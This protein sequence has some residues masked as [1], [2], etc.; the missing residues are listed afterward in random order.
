MTTPEGKVK[1][2]V[3]RALE[4]LPSVYRFMPVQNGM[5]APGLDFY[6]CIGGLFVAI[7]TKVPGK[8]LTARQL[9]TAQEIASAGGLVFVI[10]NDD[11][12]EHMVARLHVHV[13][14]SPDKP[15]GFVFDNSLSERSFRGH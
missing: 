13:Q 3:K 4:K 5:G 14:F 6:L 10:R 1:A 7:E 12:I 2:K 8:P 15:R 9:T 11:D